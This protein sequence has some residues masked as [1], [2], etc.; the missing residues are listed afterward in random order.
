MDPAHRCASVLIVDDDA[1]TRELLH[2]MFEGECDQVLEAPDGQAA[3]D[4]LRASPVPLVVLLDWRMP[5]MD[6][7]QVLNAIAA[8]PYIAHRHAYILLTALRMTQSEISECLPG[9]VP[10]RVV[11][12][13]F[14]IDDVLVTVQTEAQRFTSPAAAMST[15]RASY[16]L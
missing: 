3:L 2:I 13:P 8:D 12:K 11:T 4:C 6:G 16:S 9:T 10:V 1:S 5:G 15:I 7:P 14:D